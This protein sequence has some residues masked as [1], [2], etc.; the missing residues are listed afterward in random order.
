MAI[1]GGCYCGACRYRIALDRLD[2]V[3][4]C[5]CSICRRTTGGAFVTWA[6]VPKSAFE[7]LAGRPRDYAPND[8]SRRWFCPSCGAQLALWTSLSPET[9]DITVT[10]LDRAEDHPPNRH[11][12][13][14]G[15]L[16]WVFVDDGLP[17]EA[18]E[19]YPDSTV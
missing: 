14:R 2:D 16:D 8:T 9:I 7:W 19:V 4:N 11:I 3:A 6:T 5:H 12:F 18:E 15:K 10:T 1:E 17:Q 13:V